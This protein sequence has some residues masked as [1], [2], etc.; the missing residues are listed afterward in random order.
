MINTKTTNITFLNMW[1]YLQDKQVENNSFMLQLNDESLK[2][3]KLSDLEI[4]D[5]EKRSELIGKVIYECKNN[6]WFFFRELIKIPNKVAYSC[7]LINKLKLPSSDYILNIEEL[8]LIYSYENNISVL[9]QLNP[10]N[11]SKGIRTTI[12][13]LEI[14][15]IL[16]K[17]YDLNLY[18]IF[19]YYERGNTFKMKYY[20]KSLIYTNF[21][22]IPNFDI[23]N[24][25]EKITCSDDKVEIMLYGRANDN[26][27]FHIGNYINLKMLLNNI[28]KTKFDGVPNNIY[29][30]YYEIKTSNI[31]FSDL[32]WNVMTKEL[33]CIGY[34]TLFDNT[35]EVNRDKLYLL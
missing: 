25:I 19:N 31:N 24:D 10:L 35:E 2:D 11:L 20:Y 22:I 21:S 17:R 30:F 33:K 27:F 15:T 26:F 23:V 16:F 1:R 5:K 3:F 28:Y 8:K 9:A 6:I 12:C 32:S 29:G 13:L 4:D 14:Y 18:S 34:S 7:D